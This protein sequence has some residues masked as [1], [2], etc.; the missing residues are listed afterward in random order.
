MNILYPVHGPYEVR[1]IKRTI[2]L[3]IHHHNL[4]QG[5]RE[6][7]IPLP[8]PTI[9]S[10]IHQEVPQALRGQAEAFQHH[11]QRQVEVT[12]PLPVQVGACQHLH[13]VVA[14]LP[15]PLQEGHQEVGADAAG[16][17]N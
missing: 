9:A 10:Q 12:L 13:P 8:G 2:R 4:N 17:I 1:Q 5:T 6:I 11:R 14:D 7:I 15:D 16:K 3:G